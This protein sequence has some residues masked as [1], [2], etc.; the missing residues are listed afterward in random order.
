MQFSSNKNVKFTNWEGLWIWN[1]FEFSKPCS[2]SIQLLFNCFQT[3][4]QFKITFFWLEICERL[5]NC[6][7][8]FLNNKIRTNLN[9]NAW[10]T[11]ERNSSM[12]FFLLILV[13]LSSISL[14]RQI[15]SFP[16]Q[17]NLVSL[18]KVLSWNTAIWLDHLLATLPGKPKKSVTG[19]TQQAGIHKIGGLGCCDWSKCLKCRIT[20]KSDFLY[21]G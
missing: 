15:P 7:L 1:R 3:F 5:G 19:Q 6:R 14:S 13:N 10:T 8:C 21:T 4:P 12:E 9:T 18:Q 11:I 17:L 2:Q 16:C 20:V